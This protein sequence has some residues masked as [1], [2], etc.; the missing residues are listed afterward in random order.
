[1]KRLLLLP[2]L[3]LVST[4]WSLAA[5]FGD[6]A[7]TVSSAHIQYAAHHPL[8]AF[9]ATS[10][11]IKGKVVCAQKACEVLAGVPV[12]SFD[13]SNANRDAHMLEITKGLQFPLVTFHG[14]FSAGQPPSELSGEAEFSGHRHTIQLKEIKWSGTETQPKVTALASFGLKDFGIE[15]P[16]LLGVAMSDEIKL[17]IEA[18]FKKA[19]K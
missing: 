6:G 16:S 12:K 11:D 14:K 15:A 4:P 13:S 9:E 5:G 18:E 1:M 8:H 17:S 2:S 10:H 3:L 19:D 7:Y